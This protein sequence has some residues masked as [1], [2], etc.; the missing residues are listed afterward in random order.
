MIECVLCYED[1]ETYTKCTECG[2][3]F[4]DECVDYFVCCATPA[5]FLISGGCGTDGDRGYTCSVFVDGCRGKLRLRSSWSSRSSR[6]LK[7]AH[8]FFQSRLDRAL[9]LSKCDTEHPNWAIANV[10]EL[11]KLVES[12]PDWVRESL[13][14]PAYT[15][16][17]WE[18]RSLFLRAFERNTPI[19]HWDGIGEFVLRAMLVGKIFP[20]SLLTL[21]GELMTFQSFIALLKLRFPDVLREQLNIALM[22]SSLVSASVGSARMEILLSEGADPSYVNEAGED[23]LSISSLSGNHPNVASL[24]RFSEPSL[25]VLRRSVALECSKTL[26]VIL[27]H[28]S[29]GNTMKTFLERTRLLSCAARH[30]HIQIIRSL[31]SWGAPITGEAI[32]IAYENGNVIAFSHMRAIKTRVF[33]K[34]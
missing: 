10:P 2:G 11:I 3:V 28:M 33:T 21:S 17:Q 20:F 6:S 19:T 34:I 9:V 4:C 16:E 18:M 7:E 22:A 13:S 30:G 15:L 12:C 5:D 25:R 26:E 14:Y 32:G 27:S 1:S 31:I 29:K 23:A 8:D 24:L